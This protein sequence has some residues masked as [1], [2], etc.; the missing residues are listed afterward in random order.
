MRLVLAPRAG[1]GFL[2]V[3]RD[4]QG[5]RRRRLRLAVARRWVPIRTLSPVPCRVH[6]DGIEPQP[7]RQC[8]AGGIAARPANADVAAVGETSD[9]GWAACPQARERLLPAGVT[10]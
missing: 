10:H 1:H 2:E 5:P 7:W 8:K 9:H 3:R 4:T 6:I